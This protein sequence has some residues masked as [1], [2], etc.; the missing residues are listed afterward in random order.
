MKKLYA[1][2]SYLLYQGR[3]NPFILIREAKA[4]DLKKNK[5]NHCLR[6]ENAKRW[7]MTNLEEI[8]KITGIF[9]TPEEAKEFMEAVRKEEW[10]PK[11][12]HIVGLVF[13]DKEKE[14]ND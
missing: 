7:I 12:I 8:P 9:I 10:C 13:Q 3:E 6:A 5:F 4:K 11:D 1:L 2:G 14:N